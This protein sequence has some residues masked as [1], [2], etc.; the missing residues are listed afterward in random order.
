MFTSPLDILQKNVSVTF[1]DA[2]TTGLSPARSRLPLDAI[3]SRHAVA[4]TVTD[5]GSSR[6]HRNA[7]PAEGGHGAATPLINQNH[8]KDANVP[9][10]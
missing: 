1:A 5:Q 6:P 8:T 3:P 4:W 7:V 2:N 10:V 9:L